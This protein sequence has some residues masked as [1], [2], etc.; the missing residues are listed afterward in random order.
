MGLIENIFLDGGIISGGLVIVFLVSF[1]SIFLYKKFAIKFNIVANPN[2]RTLHEKPMPTGGGFIFS[3]FF[4]A[5]IL[6]LW[7]SNKVSLSILNVFFIGALSATLFGFFDDIINLNASKKLIVQI[8][9]SCWTLYSLSAVFFV[10]NDNMS[11][12]FLFLVLLFF[13]VWFMNAFNFMDGIDGL[14]IS[15]SV[16]FCFIFIVVLIASN[17]KTELIYVFLFLLACTSSFMFFNWPPA[18]I[19]MGD[20]GSIFLGYTFGALALFT[21]GSGAI[22]AWTWLVVFGYF[23]ADTF[24]TQILRL[25][26]VKKWYKAHRSHAYQNLARIK[27]NHLFVTTGITVY[28]V[29]WILPLSI[30]TI[31]QPEYA[32]FAVLSAITPGLIFTYLYGPIFSSS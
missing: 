16:F 10:N 24:M 5:S 30:W 9:L 20:S 18:T 1:F 7:M 13:S 31:L 32:H 25:F 12:I 23:F 4:V 19:F 3:L 17:S 26:L 21:V 15:G 11:N 8:V 14:A 6:T 2:F 28:H 29:I 27:N 22:S